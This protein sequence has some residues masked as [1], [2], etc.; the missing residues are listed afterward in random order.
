LDFRAH[1]NSGRIAHLVKTLQ[2]IIFLQV[3]MDAF[4]DLMESTRYRA[5]PA[6]DAY[7]FPPTM[8][9]M[10]IDRKIASEGTTKQV[11]SKDDMWGRDSLFMQAYAHVADELD[12]ELRQTVVGKL[13]DGQK[14]AFIVDFKGEG[15]HDNGGPYRELFGEISREL[16]SGKISLFVKT[17]NNKDGNGRDQGHVITNPTR[18][19]L[20]DQNLYSFV[21]VL[22]AIALRTDVTMPLEL[23][24]LFWKYLVSET[25]TIED[26]DRINMKL[27]QY[28]SEIENCSEEDFGEKYGK[29]KFTIVSER[30]GE[31]IELVRNGKNIHLTCNNRKE[32]K[33]RLVRFQQK[34]DLAQFDAIRRGYGRILPVE[35]L[36]IFTWREL[37]MAVCGDP[38]LDIEQLKDNAI[39]EGVAPDAPYI[40]YFWKLLEELS[41]DLHAHFLRFVWARSRMPLYG[42][43]RNIKIQAPPPNSH[44]NPDQ[45]HPTSRTCFFSISIPQY[46]SYDVAKE[47]I[48]YAIK[49]CKDMDND[50]RMST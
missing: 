33:E 41:P 32:Y 12:K 35:Y 10:E 19:N 7:S 3:K 31:D 8:L 6:E 23:P 36:T 11:M 34:K 14:R 39:Y 47:K 1:E 48:L 38:E 20:L 43:S 25:P 15:V 42:G 27:V 28:L 16:Q 13:D 30:D 24:R 9:K 17:P 5:R 50:F 26:L 4:N 44:D 46:S 22:M 21:G 45:Y 37:E 2:D 29:T 18:C 40:K 49:H